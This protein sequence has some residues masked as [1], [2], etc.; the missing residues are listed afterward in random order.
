MIFH[1]LLSPRLPYQRG[2]WLG[3]DCEPGQEVRD[4]WSETQGA[5]SGLP[6]PPQ[7]LLPRPA[8]GHT[9]PPDGDHDAGGHTGGRQAVSQGGHH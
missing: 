9:R 5:A 3:G 8:P 4:G 2:P 1:L 6:H 7:G